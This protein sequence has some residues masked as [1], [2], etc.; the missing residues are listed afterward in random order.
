MVRDTIFISHA[1][2]EDNEFAIWLASRLQMMGYEVWLDKNSLLGGEKFWGDIEAVL[3]Y[4]AIKVL[5]IY[6][7]NICQRDDSGQYVLGKLKSGILK[8][9]T[10]SKE[11]ATEN[12]IKDFII[13]LNVDQAPF[14]L[15]DG[16]ETLNQIPFSENWAS[17]LSQLKKKLIGDTVPKIH[18]TSNTEFRHWYETSFV[19]PNGITKKKELYYSNWWAIKTLPEYFYIYKFQKK[20]QADTIAKQLKSF[21]IGKISNNLACFN[22]YNEFV[23]I[24]KIESENEDE[25]ETENVQIIPQETH[26][27]KVLDVLLGFERDS[28]PNHRDSEN[29]LKKL[30]QVTFHQLMKNRKLYWYEMANKKIVEEKEYLKKSSTNFLGIEENIR[31]IIE[32]IIACTPAKRIVY[33]RI[34]S[35]LNDKKIVLSIK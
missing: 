24:R 22:F 7:T 31:K 12:T 32:K 10:L 11:I 5:L 20:E 30:L 14:N 18:D 4:R 8:E 2:P 23:V 17:G 28:F 6:S 34:T 25:N 13:P 1:T 26:K 15:F 3:R 16:S 27:I 9:L 33:N 35:K 29:H 19:N 21:P